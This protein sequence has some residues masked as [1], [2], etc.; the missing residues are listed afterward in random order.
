[1]MFP[2][3]LPTARTMDWPSDGGWTSPRSTCWIRCFRPLILL[4]LLPPS[5]FSP[6]SHNTHLQC[7]CFG[8]ADE[9]SRIKK[10]VFSNTTIVQ[11]LSQR[12]PD[13]VGKQSSVAKHGPFHELSPSSFVILSR[14]RS[15]SLSLS[16]A[17][18]FVVAL[19]VVCIVKFT[20][21]FLSIHFLFQWIY[22]IKVEYGYRRW[23]LT[24]P[25]SFRFDF[26]WLLPSPFFLFVVWVPPVSV[27]HGPSGF[28]SALTHLRWFGNR[29]KIS[30][31]VWG[32]WQRWS[33]AVLGESSHSVWTVVG[34]AVASS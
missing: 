7:R 8:L 22:I 3:R 24:P 2:P 1:M 30:S 19:N 20:F 27:V 28:W 23:G 11:E 17:A 33:A 6:S 18:A 12:C 16:P 9:G 21:P 32:L 29:G 10:K 4:F 25:F 14:L 15:L 34:N 5:A 13:L 31:F 26:E